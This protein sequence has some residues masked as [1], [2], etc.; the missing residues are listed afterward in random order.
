MDWNSPAPSSHPRAR[1]RLVHLPAGLLIV[2]I[3]IN[4]EP[5]A[6]GFDDGRI[7]CAVMF[8][9]RPNS[10][11]TG[12]GEPTM[13]RQMLILGVAWLGMGFSAE[14]RSEANQAP[15]GRARR[16]SARQWAQEPTS[17]R[18][19]KAIVCS[20]IDGYESYKKQP[21]AALTSDEKLLVYYRP[22]GYKTA[23]VDGTYQAHFTQ[24][25]QVR[26]RGEK[27]ILREKKKLL[28]CTAKEDLPPENLFLRNSVSL[29]GLPPG[30]Y[31][32]TIILHDEIAQGPPTTQVVRFRI[33]PADVVAD[34][35]KDESKG[36]ESSRGERTP[37]DADDES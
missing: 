22:L 15:S 37:K 28:D 6:C 8:R 32:F 34:P 18:M 14:L 11:G 17:L 20:S 21:G 3:R 12:A 7:I 1:R 2:M 30:E 5:P 24:D 13:C 29:K 23:F 4:L 16:S 26:K 10:V 19:S 36:K 27:A 35:P 25:G 31:D 9:D 33:V